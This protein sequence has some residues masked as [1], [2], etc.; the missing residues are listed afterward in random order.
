MPTH[1][2]NGSRVSRLISSSEGSHLG[3]NGDSRTR[4]GTT[5]SSSEYAQLLQQQEF[6]SY[7][8]AAVYVHLPFCASR[9]LS[10]SNNTTVTHDPR[11]VDRYLD[12][13]DHEMDLATQQMGTG[14]PLAQLHL[15]GGTPNYLSEP[16]LMRLMG[17]IEQ[18]FVLADSTV[19]SLDASPRR[20]S[21]TQLE[22][23]KGL[24]FQHINFEVRD[25]NP[26]V[27]RALGRSDSLHMLQDVFNNARESGLETISMDL[28]YGL[29]QQSMT[30]IDLSLQQ[31]RELSPDRVACHTYSRRADTF[32]HQRAIDPGSL[33]SLSDRLVMFNAIV[34]RMQDDGYTWVG[35]DYFAKSC[36]P[37]A[38]AQDQHLLYRNWI[39]YNL[40]GSPNMLGFGT[41]AITETSSGACTQNHLHIP[42]WQ[43]AV[44]RNELPIRGGVMLSEQEQ[45]HRRAMSGLLCNME[46]GDYAALLG[47]EED[48]SSLRHLEE[49]GVI[50]I[51][52]GKAVITAQGRYTLHHIFGDTSHRDPW[53]SIW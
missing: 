21:S 47:I 26:E 31:I 33:P 29:P 44:S 9:C 23:L 14:H 11:D 15:G 51:C 25:L 53:I 27:Q 18:Y 34:E 24:G 50:Q 20:S 35:L 22:L 6:V 38:I 2:K 49:D 17:I 3:G 41:N 28:V 42:E 10:C 45:Q 1:N 13:L 7:G 37:L 4:P 5:L 8:N 48:E 43:A 12:N 40:H 19:M 39:G 16:Q 52:D 32:N 30:S 46:L 36:D